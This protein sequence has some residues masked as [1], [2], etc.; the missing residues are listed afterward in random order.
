MPIDIRSRNDSIGRPRAFFDNISDETVSRFQPALLDEDFVGLENRRQ[1]ANEEILGR[2][3]TSSARADEAQLAGAVGGVLRPYR[4]LQR[5]A[6][7]DADLRL[8]G[9]RRVESEGQG[10]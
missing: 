6:G 10:G 4:H 2:D 3:G 5:V 8:A 7:A 9:Y 1:I